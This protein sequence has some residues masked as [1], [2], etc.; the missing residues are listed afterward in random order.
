M[1]NA[2][3][4][5]PSTNVEHAHE[6]AIPP[7][8]PFFKS[9]KASMKET[10]FP[11]DPLQQFKNQPPVAKFKLG[12]QYFLPILEWG[13]RYT[14]Q[15]LKADL[16]SGITIASLAIP[17]GISYA[18]LANL[19][20]IL[21]LYSSF[22]P[23]LVYAMMG[24]SRDLA[25]GTVAVASLLTASM[26]GNEVNA[27]ENPTLY[28]H[29]AFTATFFAGVFQ[30]SLG[31][32]RL[33]FI[34]DFLSHA[35]I[36]GF[37]A[38]AATVVCLQQLKGILGLDHFTHGTD[39]VSVMRSVFSQTHR[40]RWE[41]A[42]LGFCFLFYLLLARFF[43]GELKKGLNPLS[44]MDLSFGTPYLSTIIKTG[45]IT[46]VIALAEGIAVGRSF[47]MY[48]NYQIDG[49]KE[50]I[51][52]GM[53]N[54]A[55]SFTSCYLTTGPF[56]RSA[57]NFNAGCKTAVSNIVMALAV[58]ITLLFLTPLFHY[59][60]LVVLS[61]IIIAAMLGL[62]D[63]EAA[64]HLWQVDKFDFVVC[65]SAYMGVVF[66]SVEIGLVIAVALSL[67]RILLFVA[68][69]RTLVLGNIPDSM[70][71]RSVDQY[72]NA[73]NVPGIL[74]LEIDAPMYFANSSYLRE[75]ISRWIDE[76]EDKLKS[77]GEISLQYVIFDMGAVGNIDTSG[78][79]MLEEVKKSTDRR[80]LTMVLANPG[81]EVMKK[82]NKSR[83][84]ELIGQE[85]IYLTVGEAVGAC[86]YMLHT[87]KPKPKPVTTSESET[88]GDNV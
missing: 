15:F 36:V 54:I 80:G 14:F 75:R 9:L 8:Q 30:A 81:G 35:T 28:L 3:Y 27:N 18:K 79:S 67:L 21:G 24:S 10:F 23:P 59:T 4:T 38:G 78:I 6:V 22:V 17:Q 53:M 56:S 47:A 41:S 60:P 74:I 49:N 48:K 52:F 44:I 40:W 70:I 77:S 26:L 88:W 2:D 1:G 39:L 82:L 58:M 11:D 13:P 45:I 61:S 65:M 43:I 76:E 72:P 71:Y 19:P 33:G 57:V 68:R 85:W 29:L 34:V 84:I 86:N 73:N 63:Y 31:I 37:M 62:I 69:P 83:L 55:G 25:V 51:A 66:G 50:M 20:P 87:C 32:L 5:Y 16:I 7:P 64:I 12:L 46:G 42:V